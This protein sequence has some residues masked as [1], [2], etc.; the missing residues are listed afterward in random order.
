MHSIAPENIKAG[1]HNN[2]KMMA[3]T[4]SFASAIMV[5]HMPAVIIMTQT[6]DSKNP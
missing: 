2:N 6:S 4:N 3:K 1:I 5:M